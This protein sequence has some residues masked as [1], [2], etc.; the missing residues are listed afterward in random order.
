MWYEVRHD[1]INYDY[2]VIDQNQIF[3]FISISNLLLHRIY[4]IMTI[5]KLSLS[6]F[7]SLSI[8]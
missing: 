7:L 1:K 5:V 3:Y 8:S 4:V 2:L 6:L